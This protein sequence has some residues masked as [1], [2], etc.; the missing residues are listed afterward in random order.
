MNNYHK[1][2]YLG[3]GMTNLSKE[4][5]N[6]WREK[7]E[8]IFSEQYHVNIFNPNNHWDIDDSKVSNREA[9]E[10]DLFRLR[11]CDVY[12]INFNDPESLGSM[13]ELAI[14]HELRIP[15]IGICP[16][17]HRLVLHPWQRMMCNHFCENI[18]EAAEY[19]LSHYCFND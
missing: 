12:V 9:M 7:F 16:V 2:F 10:Y 8:E 19:L 11:G 15:V 3:G 13:A 17:H 18:E 1:I 5:S 4:E 14:A 6:G